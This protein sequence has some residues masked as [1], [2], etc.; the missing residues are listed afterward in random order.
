MKIKIT[1]V[2]FTTTIILF[3][4][5]CSVK[6]NV[7]LDEKKEYELKQKAT[8]V[9]DKVVGLMQM[10][11]YEKKQEGGIINA[12]T[13]CS[14]NASSLAKKSLSNL[15]SGVSIKRITTKPRNVK[16]QASKEEIV[17]LNK[18]KKQM[19]VD[20]KFDMYIEQKSPKHFQVYKPI[21]IM[22][23][24]LKCHGTAQ[25]RHKEAYKIIEKKYP[26]D[27]AI[28]YKLYDF[29]GAFLVDIIE[30]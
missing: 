17:I 24:C 25:T 27:K 12:A 22:G 2:L 18:I 26:N 13:F 1:L 21:K 29:R 19:H 4:S 20:K 11:I 16:N 14:E 8:K 9:I 7:N 28:D 6:Q 23:L 3:L 5:A 30:K 15:P 10:S